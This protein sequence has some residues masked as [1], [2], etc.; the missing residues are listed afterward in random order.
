LREAG[1]R[2]PTSP[3]QRTRRGRQPGPL[4]VRVEFVVG[5]GPPARALRERQTEA[6]AAILRWLREHPE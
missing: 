5:D 4:D 6:I 1:G 3:E 2:L